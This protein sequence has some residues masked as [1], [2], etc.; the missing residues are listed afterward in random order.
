MTGVRCKAASLLCGRRIVIT[1][2][3]Y[4]ILERSEEFKMGYAEEY[5]QKLVTADQAAAVI[6]DGDWV[7]Y[8]WTATT[9]VAVD[10]ALA[11]KMPEMMSAKNTLFVVGAAHLVG[12][13]GVL[14]LMRDAGYV[15]EPVTR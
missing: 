10:K 12:E 13:K 7:D 11:K 4:S 14:Q 3:L 8:G 1:F 9:C 15:V 2:T 5:K 6:Q